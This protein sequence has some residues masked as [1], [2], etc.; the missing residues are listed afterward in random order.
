MRIWRVRVN[1][2]GTKYD[3]RS[4]HLVHAV[5]A[6]HAVRKACAAAKRE[7]CYKRYDA[8]LVEFVGDSI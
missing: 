2:R 1:A 4:V 6:E 8:E 3:E 5:T 7:G